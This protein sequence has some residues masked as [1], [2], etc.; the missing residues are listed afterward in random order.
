MLRSF[1][2]RQV[3][4]LLVSVAIIAFAAHVLYGALQRIDF[5]DVLAHVLQIPGEQLAL[6]ALLV[7][8]VFTA[9]ALYETIVAKFIRAPVS[10]RRAAITSLIATPI[11]HAIG[12]GALSGGAVRYRL[13]SAVGMRPLD[14]GKMIL[15]AA[16]PYAGGLG[17]LLGLALVVRADEAAGILRVQEELARGAGLALLALHGAY[18]VLI[19]R[20]RTPVALGR[21]IVTLP[22]PQLTLVQYAIGIVDVC[23]AAAVLYFLL[24]GSVELPFL[25][26]IGVYVLGILAG[27]ASS[28]PAGLGVF[29]SM[30]LFL[31]P[32][33]P[34]DQL[35][36]TVLAYRFL[37]E[38]VPLA[39][40]LA[41][42]TAYELWWRLPPQRRRAELLRAAE[43][44]A[45]L[46]E[47]R[48]DEER[49]RRR[50]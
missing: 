49:A 42:F 14:V 29:E 39:I 38:L 22:T 10:A 44:A 30:L 40:A 50:R 6:G 7:G 13:Y 31:L 17:L 19:M 15:L 27:L 11:G 33:V 4:P 3:L 16:L 26:F 34:P 35:L 23:A 20:R 46:R 2:P 8:V 45:K 24:P 36:G 41:A 21:F 47:E 48:Q 25:L 28:V 32:G 18:V 12:W 1:G 5:A 37:L 9:L 43:L